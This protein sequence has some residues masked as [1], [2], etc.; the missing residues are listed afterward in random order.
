MTVKALRKPNLE[1][2]DY[3]CL[4]LIRECEEYEDLYFD[5]DICLRIAQSLGI[6]RGGLSELFFRDQTPKL[7]DVTNSIDVQHR[8]VFIRAY[9]ADFKK[10]L[11]A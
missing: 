3:H 4:E 5:E 1:V 2:I 9:L 8:I 6:D 7:L 11:G 10:L